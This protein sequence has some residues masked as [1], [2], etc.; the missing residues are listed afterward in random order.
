MFLFLEKKTLMGKIS[1]IKE[2]I[3][4]NV[5]IKPADEYRKASDETVKR[6]KEIIARL[7][8]IEKRSVRNSK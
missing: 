4:S 1:E 6:N 2:N 5:F 8:E 7:G 3:N